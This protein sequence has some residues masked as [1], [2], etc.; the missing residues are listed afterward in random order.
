MKKLLTILLPMFII[1]MLMGSCKKFLEQSS[2]DL[3]R[4][5]TVEH[6][7]ELLQGEAYFKDFYRNGWFVDVM[8]DDVGLVDLITPTTL[9]NTKME[10]AKF[11]YQWGPDPEDPTGTF[12]DALFQHLYKNV[13]TANTCLE[14]LE[15]MEGSEAE[16]KILKGQAS[17]TRSYAYFVLANLYAQAYN[18]A[19]PTDLCVPLI[20]ETTPSLKRFNRAT[21]KEVWD[22]IA[23]DAEAAVENLKDD[24]A[25]RSVYEINYKA[26]LLLASRVFLFRQEWDKAIEYGERF[27]QLRPDL[28][29]I[30]AITGS[31]SATG[32]SANK[33]FLLPN[34]NPEIVFTFGRL[35][36]ATTVGGYMY[37]TREPTGLSPA[38]FSASYNVPG[39]LI[40]MYGTGDR[41]KN[42][43]F[44]APTGAPGGLLVYL[45]YTPLK[46]QYYEGNRTTQFFRSAEAY[47]VLAEAYARKA[48]PDRAKAVS[49]LNEL[50]KNRI[51]SYTN[52]TTADFTTPEALNKFIIDER[53]RELCFE[54]FHRWW[55]L[56]RTGQ[57]AIE[58]RWLA[59][60][61]EL[62][63]KDPAYILNFPREEME[64]NPGLEPNIRPARSPK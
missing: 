23:A 60:V 52:L 10:Y 28:K 37:Y 63:A 15:K 3:I 42:Y 34:E 39:A 30:T 45:A 6:Y 1:I 41:R 8:S 49:L 5:V 55:D 35:T 61:Y 38:T 51:A 2:Q 20:M 17:F 18:E 29:N 57:P 21:I 56:R 19:A 48:Q 12:T 40:D 13:L 59:D 27:L 50:R 43:W 11:L 54:E 47:L 14:S 22:L 36:G 24:V 62:K 4:P 7:K 64:F 9:I 32:T 53:R 16:K 33:V 58:H 31:P 44:F 25:A 46:L 26:A